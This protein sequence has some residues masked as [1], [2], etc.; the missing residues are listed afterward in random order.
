MDIISLIYKNKQT[1]LVS[2]VVSFL[3][4][5]LILYFVLMP[6]FKQSRL[7]SSQIN[8]KKA[9]LIR[10]RSS[11]GEYKQLEDETNKA[12]KELEKVKNS[13]FWEKDISRFLNQL[14]EFASDLPLEFV[15]LKPESPVFPSP[16]ESDKKVTLGYSLTQT[17]VSVT[18]KSSFADLV[19][20]LS[21]V[22]QAEKFIKI[23]YFTI[24]SDRANIYK[25]NI[26]MNLSIFGKT[27]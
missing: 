12:K 5:G 21:R 23:D 10:V 4:T 17:P 9:Q 24:D 7:L 19:K 1:A 13:L 26:K 22:E 25:H 15:Y 18:I 11:S 8:D 16:L 6:A 3:I 27:G 14:T 2:V 20:F